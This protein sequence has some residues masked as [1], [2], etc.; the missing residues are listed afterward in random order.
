MIEDSEIVGRLGPADDYPVDDFTTLASDGGDL[1]L[2]G[3]PLV[4]AVLT[5]LKDQP[6]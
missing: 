4:A 2:P 3:W 5:S 1:R 6:R